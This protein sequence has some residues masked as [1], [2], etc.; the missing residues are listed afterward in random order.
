MRAF[1]VCTILVFCCLAIGCKGFAFRVPTENMVP[2]IKVGDTCIVDQYSK[3]EVQRFD[4]V[5]FKA[6]EAAKK[7]TRETGDVKY[8]SRIIGLPKEKIEIKDSKVFIN[9]KQLEETFEK[10]TNDLDGQ[11]DFPA[12]VIP[13]NE[14]FMMGDN[15]P[16]SLDSR[17]YKTV[18]KEEILGKV[19]EILPID[20][21]K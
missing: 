21:K 7:M 2:T 12:M 10:I 18:K 4:I 8:I 15:R 6:S 14:Y 3:I 1:I 17:Y 11:K 13:E 9:D 19:V 20:V 5:M 16:R